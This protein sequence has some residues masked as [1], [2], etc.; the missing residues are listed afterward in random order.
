MK[1]W[2]LIKKERFGGFQSMRFKEEAKILGIELRHVCAQDFEIV[3]P[4]DEPNK[5]WYKGR[6]VEVPDVLITRVAGMSY[7]SFAFVRLLERMGVCVMNS[8]ASIEMAEDKLRTIQVLTAKKLPIPVSILAK[9]P[10]D[11]DYIVNTLG[12]PLVMK[13]VHGAKGE[14]VLLL[15]N[16]N[17]FKDVVSVVHKA[18]EG[19]TNLIF[20]R[21]VTNSS[22]RDL[23]V[24]V[25]GDTAVGAAMRQ[26][27][28][29]EFKANVAMGGTAHY[30]PLDDE[31]SKLSVDATKSLGLSIAGVD[32]L[33]DEGRF[34]IGEVN[35]T[36]SFGGFEVVA[37]VN[38]PKLIL[39]YAVSIYNK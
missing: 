13:T 12:F 26:G 10:V 31:I 15:E 8:A 35:S 9:F 21:F 23:R 30:F 14:G 19:K 20:Q 18:T 5:I 38:V 32:L 7:F 33:F 22:G 4:S 25:I 29:G 2:V 28:E 39:E 24:F 1:V 11:L 34:V 17:Q 27:K 3:E 6:Y 36:P 37:K 16:Y